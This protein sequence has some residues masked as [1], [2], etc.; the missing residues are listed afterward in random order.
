VNTQVFALIAVAASFHIAVFG[1][2]HGD[3]P[4]NEGMDCLLRWFAETRPI[5]LVGTGDHVSSPR[6]PFVRLLEDSSDFRAVFLPAVADA[7]NAA[8]GGSQ[9]SPLAGAPL[10][11][12][13]GIADIDGD[14][15]F[16]YRDTVDQIPL[17]VLSLYFPDEPLDPLYPFPEASRRA[18]AG[19]LADPAL[20]SAFVLISAH[21]LDGRWDTWLDRRAWKRVHS[22]ADLLVAGSTH[23]PFLYAAP[24]ATANA[25]S[26]TRPLPFVYPCFLDL[27]VAGA[28]SF[29]LGFMDA[30]TYPPTERM[31][32]C[33]PE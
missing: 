20:E 3:G 1:D 15:C 24:A 31:R 22:R 32:F 28:E 18:L 2:N 14:C 27:E 23:L 12:L 8:W 16:Q 19:F 7:E 17:A 30:S 21:G 6:C 9:S 29:R 13:S 33:S 26:L 25:G 10:L 11:A 5:L 4:G